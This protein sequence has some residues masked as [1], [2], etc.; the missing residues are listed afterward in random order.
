M[1]IFFKVFK[2]SLL[3]ELQYKGAFISGIIC[4]IAFGL[5]Y[6]FLYSAFFENGIPQNFN[7]VQMASYIWLGQALFAMFAFFDITLRLY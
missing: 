3:E 7:Q 1:R 2:T 6:V 5:M 4:Q